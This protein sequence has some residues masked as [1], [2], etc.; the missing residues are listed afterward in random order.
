MSANKRAWLYVRRNTK[1]TL[2]LFLLFTILM[3]ISLLGFT[4]HTAS[5]AAV[6]EL[7]GSIGG[8]FMIQTG[9]EGRERTGDALLN[10]VK[11][12][13]NI[14]RWNGID[15]YYMYAEGLQLM[16]GSYSGSGTVGE[17][18]PKCIGCLDSSLHERFLASSFQLAE[19]R[20]ITPDDVHTVI[21]S[22]DVAERNGLTVGDTIPLSVV[23]GVRDWRGNAYG[24]QVTLEIVGIYITTRNEA[25][26]PTTPESE[27]QENILFTDSNTAK[28]LF[29]IKF[30][31]RTVEDYTY[32]SGIMMFLEDPARMEETVALL[33][34]QPYADWDS[35]ILS[36]NSAAYE[37]T[38]APIQ[39]AET[40]SR[41]LLLIILVIS[42]V[43][44]S[45]I[46]LMWT[47]ERMTEIGILI[48]L[49]LSVKDIC[50]QMLMENYIVAGPAYLIS[51][52]LSA[53]LAGQV[54]RLVGGVLEQVQLDAVQA[55]IVLVCAAVVV[56]VTVLLASV[57]I[58]RKRPKDILT[59][60]S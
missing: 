15:T 51:V 37:Q 8:Y 45:L 18:M 58:M 56:F 53:L 52:L 22:K 26:S 19:G 17:F 54:G 4:L 32:S 1:R 38:A 28:E 59:D 60:L 16:P 57:S 40:I 21:L 44:L 2:L 46:L 49:G 42:I 13:D 7:R 48:S 55:V 39:K 27:L 11:T 10:Q 30:P 25:V 3:T 41:L 47:R 36:E 31:D 33:K 29:L 6:K 35:L 14:S 34:Q 9:A 50:K 43:I 12:L 20:H 24:T 23:E 5:S